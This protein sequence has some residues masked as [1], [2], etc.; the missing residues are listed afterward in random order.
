MIYVIGYLVLGLITL[1]ICLI[2]HQI[3][4]RETPIRIHKC[5]LVVLAWPAVHIIVLLGAL[6]GS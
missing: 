1:I 5:I 2:S 4:D 6:Y 3:A